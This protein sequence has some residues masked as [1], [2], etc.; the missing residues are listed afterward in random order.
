MPEQAPNA[1]GDDGRVDPHHHDNLIP[2]DADL[3]ASRR[4]F[5]KG[6]IAS[7]VAVS[8]SGYLVLGRALR[9]RRRPAP[10]SGW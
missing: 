7:G 8:S 2:T 6:V 9:G 1:L 3:R 10:S 4:D 5:I